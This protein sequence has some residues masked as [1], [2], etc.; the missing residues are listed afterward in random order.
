MPPVLNGHVD[1]AIVGTPHMEVVNILKAK[2]PVVLM[3]VPFSSKVTNVPAV[4][5]N[6]QLGFSELLQELIS[7]GHKNIGTFYSPTTGEGTS[8]EIPV[9]NALSSAASM[10]G[11]ATYND[12]WIAEDISPETHDVVMKKVSLRFIELIRQRRIS[13]IILPNIE[14]AVG[15]Y[16]HLTAAGVKIPEDVSIASLYFGFH[17]IP[18]GITAVK[19]D[20]DGLTKTSLEVLKKIIDKKAYPCTEFLV[21]PKLQYGNTISK[22]TLMIRAK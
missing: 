20:W 19:Y 4:N 22:S 12:L 3:D 2:I 5:T 14:Y 8:L 1:G 7:L 15:I 21:E 17:S 10:A 11:I 6:L 13:A 9:A 18:Y 16:E